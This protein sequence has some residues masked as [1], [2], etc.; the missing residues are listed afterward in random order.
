[1]SV[2]YRIEPLAKEHDRAAFSSGAQQIDDWFHR[3]AGQATRRGVAT[4]HVLVNQ[5]TNAVIGFYTLSNFT[6]VATDLPMAIGKV[7]PARIPLPAHLIGQLAV[8]AR[9]QGKGYGAALLFDALRRA[10]R[11]TVDSAS[12]AVVVHALD[13][14]AATWYTRYGFIPFPVYPLHLFIPMKDVARLPA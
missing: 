12:L 8:D 10:Y 11:M 4:V 2:S 14:R 3:Q 7:L 1:M 6:V 13:A 5:A 9:E